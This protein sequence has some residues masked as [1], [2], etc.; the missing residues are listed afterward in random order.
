MPLRSC[1]TS[2]PLACGTQRRALCAPPASCWPT[3]CCLGAGPAG[4][5]SFWV[6]PGPAGA[7]R[8]QALATRAEAALATAREPGTGERRQA[9]PTTSQ[10]GRHHQN[11]RLRSLISGL[12]VAYVRCL[13]LS[14]CPRLS[15][16]LV[17]D[18][19]GVCSWLPCS[20]SCPAAI[21][22]LRLT[23]LPRFLAARHRNLP[24]FHRS[25]RYAAPQCVT[26]VSIPLSP[27]SIALPHPRNVPS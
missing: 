1:V 3:R 4:P 9:G 10:A 26:P 22:V 17:W 2:V 7:I 11:K 21:A 15:A 6:E 14:P 20:S 18:M 13:F 16:G 8:S 23:V 24:G 25:F 5:S 27:L 19:C 12:S